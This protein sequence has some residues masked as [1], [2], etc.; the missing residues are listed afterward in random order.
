MPKPCNG[1]PTQ[2]E[3]NGIFV[4]LSHAALYGHFKIMPVFYLY[5]GV[6]DYV[7]CVLYVPVS[8]AFLC[9]FKNWSFFFFNLSFPKE[10]KGTRRQMCG[11]IRKIWGAWG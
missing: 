3:L 2:N 11:E 7:F 5:F 10:R 6:S 1:W 8:C 9:D 4:H